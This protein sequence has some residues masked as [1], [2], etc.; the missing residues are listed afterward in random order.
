MRKVRISI[1]ILFFLIISFMVSQ[2]TM[3]QQMGDEFKIV[4][5]IPQYTLTLYQGESE[6]KAY[7]VAIGKPTAVTPIGNFRVYNRAVNPTWRPNS[8]D[9]VPPG[10]ENP[11]GI[12]WMGFFRGYGIHG[13]NDPESIGKSISGGCIRMFNYD[14]SELYSIVGIRV[15]VEVR[16]QELIESRDE[17]IVIAY[18]DVY[19]REKNYRDKITVALKEAGLLDRIHPAKMENLFSVLQKKSVIFSENWVIKVNGEFL[20]S[21]TIYDRTMIFVNAD[22]LNRFFGIEIKWDGT[23]N[24]GSL[25]GTPVS[26]YRIGEK[27]YASIADVARVLG[28]ELVA[29]DDIE[30]LN[31]RIYFVKLKGKFLTSDVASF[32]TYPEI[33]IKLVNPSKEGK[34]RIEQLNQ[35]GFS[36]QIFSKYGYIEL[37]PNLP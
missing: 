21:D 16:Y 14:I 5:D 31:Y 4:I 7:P 28:G 33:D 17:N 10:P 2:R 26:A 30:E 36:Y 20:T 1:L 13:N 12:R 35:E 24:T 25:M 8:S 23:N 3:A 18:R 19:S 11:L 15:P 6:V 29:R 27:V 9:P 22:R 34:I 37:L 32:K